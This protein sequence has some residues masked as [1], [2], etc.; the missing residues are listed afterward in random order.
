MRRVEYLFVG[1]GMANT[2]LAANGK[3]IG[4]SLCE[5][6][7]ADV[8]RQ[9]IADAE[10]ANCKLVLPIDAV[11]ATRLEA[12]ARTKVVDID[13]IGEDEMIL[14]IGPRTISQVVGL[15]ASARTLVW[16]G[17]VGAFEVPPFHTGTVSI[18]KVAA[19]LTKVGALDTIA[20][21]GDTI[22]ALN[23]AGVDA[24][25]H[26]CFDSRRRFSRMAGGQ[27]SARRRGAA[28]VH[29]RERLRP[30]EHGLSP[31]FAAASLRKRLPGRAALFPYKT[32]SAAFLRDL[33]S[34][35]DLAAN[36]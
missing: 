17:P 5:K 31:Q 36:P 28:V 33:R 32:V 22:A 2:F 16:N 20:G 30:P 35:P 21:G 34:R 15:L 3:Q 13:S 24:G 18:A 12:N 4:K 11:V 7:F 26:L 14:D 6:K 10:G 25:L 23:Q 8:A 1:G 19:Q 9:L 27:T 29:C